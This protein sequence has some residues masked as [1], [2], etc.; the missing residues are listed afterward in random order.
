MVLW[1]HGEPSHLDMWDPKPDAPTLQPFCIFL[2]V[3]GGYAHHETF[4]MKPEA[5]FDYRGSLLIA[6]LDEFGRTP[7]VNAAAGPASRQEFGLPLLRVAGAFGRQHV[8]DVDLSRVHQGVDDFAEKPAITH[9]EVRSGFRASGPFE[10]VNLVKNQ[11]RFIEERFAG[12]NVQ[13]CTSSGS[14]VT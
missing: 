9:Q 1:M 3:D 13:E 5:S 2:W 6:I 4:D 12:G 8:D 11:L 7:S 10:R 14:E